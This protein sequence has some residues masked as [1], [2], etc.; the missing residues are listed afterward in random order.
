M[1][2]NLIDH[3]VENHVLKQYTMAQT[4]VC[5]VLD[6]EYFDTLK[7]Y[8]IASV[9]LHVS[10]LFFRVSKHLNKSKTQ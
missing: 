7:K 4:M 3:A 1:A 6:K 9:L 8:Y 2:Q 5:W 10:R